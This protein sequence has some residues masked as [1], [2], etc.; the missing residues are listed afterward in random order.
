MNS[1]KQ[2]FTLNIYIIEIREVIF[3]CGPFEMITGREEEREMKH[4]T[5]I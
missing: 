2:N 1:I 4:T 3:H 5:L